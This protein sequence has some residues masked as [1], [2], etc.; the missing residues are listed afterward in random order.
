[1]RVMSM[2]KMNARA[3][4]NLPPDPEVMAGMGPLIEEMSKAGVFLGGEGLRPSSERVRV[5]LSRG[6]IAVKRGPYKG[7][8]ELI[9]GYSMIKTKSLEEALAWTRRFAA[10]GV[11]GE[12]EIGP[13]VEP[14][15][16][17]YMPRPEG[18]LPIRYLVLH[19]ASPAT[20]AGIAPTPAQQKAMGAIMTEM[21]QAGVLISADGLQPS[22]KAK[23]VTIARGKRTIVDGPFTESKELIAGYAMMNVQSM[24]EAIAWAERFAAVVG[25]VEMDI[26][27]VQ[28]TT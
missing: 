3:E 16:I 6:E 11:E 28:E 9:A 2:Q 21:A 8:N 13:I 24:Q 22:S 14:W 7:D 17:G 12:I 27:P 20:E 26:R 18:E 5:K 15:D 19:K 4:A 10:A 23:R 25:D 1:M